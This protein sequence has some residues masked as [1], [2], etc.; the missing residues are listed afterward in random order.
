MLFKGADVALFLYDVTDTESLS[1]A[2][3][4]ISKMRDEKW[5]SD[6]LIVAFVGG[7]I[8]AADKRVVSKEERT[9]SE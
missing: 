3:N 7:G 5:C 6:K 9:G 1:D 4:L 8:D 2:K